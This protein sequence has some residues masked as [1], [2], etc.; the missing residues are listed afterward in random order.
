M[1]RRIIYASI[2]F[3]AVIALGACNGSEAPDGGN[4]TS[5][6]LHEIKIDSSQKSVV[7]KG[8]SLAFDM[9]TEI[10]DIA[11]DNN[12]N[13]FYSPLSLQMALSL[14]ANGAEGMALDE[15]ISAYADGNGS[16]GLDNL[17][18]LGRLLLDELPLVDR[19]VSVSIANSI[20]CETEQ[21]Y[22]SSFSS[23]V[24]DY[25]DATSGKY[26]PGT[27]EARDIINRWC[28]ENTQGMINNFLESNPLSNAMLLNASYFKGKWKHP[29]NRSSTHKGTFHCESGRSKEVDMMSQE[30]YNLSGAENS[31]MAYV[32]LP[33]GN[34][35]YV[36]RILMPKSGSDFNECVEKM[37]NV[38][39]IKDE[40]WDAAGQ[41][42]L[43]M[44]RFEVSAGYDMSKALAK[45]GMP[46]LMTSYPKILEGKNFDVSVVY[47]K[48][49]C[50]VDESGT[51]AASVTQVSTVSGL[52]PIRMF[53]LTIDRPFFFTIEETSTGVVLFMGKVAK[54]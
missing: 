17:N 25:F 12:G 13:Q 9:W 10:C 32:V 49:R 19:G 50:I 30:G 8:N 43:T 46:N 37:R 18:S 26:K 33:Y 11:E 2:A 39:F 3:G 35:G 36:M 14:L 41:V 4:D 27:D 52:T 28:S 20:W 34:G 6:P 1:R 29:F 15:I 45:S 7:Q 31:Q 23:A 24:T 44:P 40:T 22:L 47:Q 48:S 51:E 53:D 38:N 16:G 5:S 54:F 21:E 42:R